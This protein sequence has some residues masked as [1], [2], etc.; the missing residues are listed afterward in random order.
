MNI[1]HKQILD[2]IQKEFNDRFEETLVVSSISSFDKPLITFDNN[3]LSIVYSVQDLSDSLDLCYCT[4]IYYKYYI[5]EIQSYDYD[6]LLEQGYS[7]DYF[8]GDYIGI[9]ITNK[10]ENEKV[11]VE[12]N[13]KDVE[14]AYKYM[15]VLFNK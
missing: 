10:F 1:V 14:L 2:K 13:T 3:K 11:I 8:Q 15:N 4:Y 5:F 12:I 7:E 6:D 9:I